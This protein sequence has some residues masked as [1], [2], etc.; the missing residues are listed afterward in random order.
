MKGRKIISWLGRL[1]W[2]LIFT[3]LLLGNFYVKYEIHIFPTDEVIGKNETLY[4]FITKI[5]HCNV[6][7]Q[8]FFLC[9]F[10]HYLG[11]LS[12]KTKKKVSV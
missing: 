7:G 12:K 4:E 10:A 9:L 3:Y 8:V 11:C 1:L 6:G 5:T 2:L